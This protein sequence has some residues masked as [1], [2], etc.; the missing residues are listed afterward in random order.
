MNKT[1]AI[2]FFLFSNGEDS[3]SK[4]KE[5]ENALSDLLLMNIED[6]IL[7]LK[8]TIDLFYLNEKIIYIMNL[9]GR[10]STTITTESK[11]D[12]WK[13]NNMPSFINML[14]GLSLRQKIIFVG[15]SICSG[16]FIFNWGLIKTGNASSGVFLEIKH[17]AP[18]SVNSSFIESAILQLRNLLEYKTRWKKIQGERSNDDDLIHVDFLYKAK[19]L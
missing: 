14:G 15:S 17:I 10:E 19:I 8:K 3:C 16:D 18:F 4:L 6:K 11:E 7:P 2:S 5:L 12:I 9:E 1:E 13:I